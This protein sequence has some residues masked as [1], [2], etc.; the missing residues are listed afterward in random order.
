MAANTRYEPAPQR[1]SFEDRAF[2]QPPPSYQ[3]TAEYSQAPRN[4]DDNVPDDFKFGGM[5][6]E[7]TL[8]IRMQFVRKVYA[9]LTAQ[10]LLTVIMSSISFFSD[11]YRTWIQG[12]F[13]LMIVSVFGALGFMLVTYWKRKSYPA[14]LLFL[15][16]FTVLEAYSISVVTSFYESRIVVQALILTLGMFVALTLFACQTKYDFTNWMPYL[17]GALW[18][19]ILFGFVAAFLPGS[20]TVE[21]IYSGLAA[22]I[23]SAYI[24]VDTQLI[25]R[26]YHVE[27]EIAASISLY[28]D[29]LNLF[30]AI[31][32]ILNNQQNN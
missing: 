22:L 9:I 7:G 19:L 8:P 21:L 14:N 31:L 1:D 16:A 11:S 5:V 15:T 3:A 4:E 24:L 26:H 28:L 12:N 6:A 10:L 2:S 23:F 29:I 27:E 25:M 30:L 13:W 17:F 20:S 18:F 32:R